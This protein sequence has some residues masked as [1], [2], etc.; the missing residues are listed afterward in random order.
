MNVY[1]GLELRD[2]SKKKTQFFPA[3]GLPFFHVFDFYSLNFYDESIRKKNYKMLSFSET[4]T[5][6]GR[7]SRTKFFLSSTSYHQ[8][9]A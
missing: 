8:I 2:S 1:L 6:I 3:G 7:H 4:K 9:L 5:I